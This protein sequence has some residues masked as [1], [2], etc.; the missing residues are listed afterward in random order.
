MEDIAKKLG[1]T[2]GTVSKAMSGA[3]DVSESMR[4]TIMETA[5]ELGYTRLARTGE[6]KRLCIFIENMLYEKPEDFGFGLITGFKKMAVPET[7]T[8]DV[9]PIDVNL[10]KSER[11]D[12]FMMR[13]N[14]LGAFF[15][16]LTLTDPWMQD[17]KTSR[18][19]V[20]LYDNKVKYNPTITSIGIDNEE[21]MELAVSA[22][23]EL[24]HTKIGYLSSSLGSRVFQMRYMAF[25]HAMRQNGL[26][27][28]SALIGKA[29]HTSENLETNLPRLLSHGCTAVICS[30]D[31]LAHSVMIHL[32]ELGVKIP[33]N[34][35]V[36]GFDDLPLCRYTSPPLSSI[37]Q[38]TEELGRSAF[39]AL[40]S[41]IHH[42]PVS[43]L[44][45]H[46][47]LVRRDSMGKAKNSK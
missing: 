43:T 14:Y 9:I 39:H 46:A 7:Y 37:R 45:L 35:S 27:V 44:L 32:S 10:E 25:R 21:G 36:V 2:K 3:P 42:I 40:L 28:D 30:H 47:E 26:N 23:K 6:A 11:Y 19:P 31:T 38:N 12:A 5:V 8:V 33:E 15:L 1:V 22:L 17:F 4:K 13:N 16:G 20:V 41:L 18:T 34:I 24:G 29:Y